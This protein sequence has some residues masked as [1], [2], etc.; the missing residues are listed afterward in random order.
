MK[1]TNQQITQIDEILVLNGLNYDDLKLEVIDHIASEVEVLMDENTLS[2]DEN[3][4]IVFKKWEDQLTPS[5]SYWIRNNKS[6]PKMV[7]QKCIKI[8]QHVFLMSFTFGLITTIIVT[9]IIKNVSNQETLFI[10]NSLLKITSISGIVLLIYAKYKVWKSKHFSSYGYLFNQN[11]FLQIFNLIFIATGVF[12][13]KD[14]ATF[15]DFHFIPTFFPI[16]F[17]FISGFYLTLAFK[18]LEFI[19]KIDSCNS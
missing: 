2:F 5:S 14:N 7:V 4:K 1:L 13:F 6:I 16:I 3:L 17:L 11:G 15:F 8:M 12:Q 19:K 9:L 18:H 10:L